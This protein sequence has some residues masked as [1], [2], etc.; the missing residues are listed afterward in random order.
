MHGAPYY[1]CSDEKK[2]LYF[3]WSK[4]GLSVDT[5]NFGRRNEIWTREIFSGTSR[6]IIVLSMS[7]FVFYIVSCSSSQ[8]EVIGKLPQQQPDSVKLKKATIAYPGVNDVPSSDMLD[9]MNSPYRLQ[10]D[11]RFIGAI[12]IIDT[13]L[14]L[15]KKKDIQVSYREG[16]WQVSNN[17][18]LLFVG[19]EDNRQ[20][21]EVAYYIG[22]MKKSQNRIREAADWFRV[23]L[24]TGLQNTPTY[25]WSFHE[26]NH[27]YDKEINL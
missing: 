14:N 21:C 26:L 25:H 19:I 6:C 11:R 23:S 12:T 9:A 13:F 18:E 10:P 1:C 27:W 4:I 5:A 16:S 17:D 2:S 8:D 22:L 20:R 15:E 7:F 3:L 24:E